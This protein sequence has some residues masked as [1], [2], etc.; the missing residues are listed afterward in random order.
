V[1]ES[2]P[3]AAVLTQHPSHR[4]FPRVYRL[5]LP[6]LLLLSLWGCC[7]RCTSTRSWSTPRTSRA[8]R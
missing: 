3:P 6:W 7:R 4:S 5:P 8:P 2:D 1:H